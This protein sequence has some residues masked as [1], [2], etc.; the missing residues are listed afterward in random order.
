MIH[1]GNETKERGS[2]SSLK[3]L[4]RHCMCEHVVVIHASQRHKQLRVSLQKH[5][6]WS[7]PHGHTEIMVAL[8]G[9]LTTDPSG[10][11]IAS[12]ET[13]TNH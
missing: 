10:Y 7:S 12:F 13:E 11:Y 8:C 9:G 6:R 5:V 3:Y 2:K 4:L 1:K